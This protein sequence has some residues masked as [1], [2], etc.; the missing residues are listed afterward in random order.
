MKRILLTA[1]LL[2]SACCLSQPSVVSE[3]YLL[4]PQGT[5]EEIGSI[6]ITQTLEGLLFEVDLNNLPTGQHGFHIHEN[7]RCLPSQ[8][9]KGEL[10]LAGQAGGHYDPENTNHHLGPK[11]AGHKGDLPFLL[12]DKEGKVKTSFYHPRLTLKEIKNRSLVI[13]KNGDNYQDKPVPLGGGGDRIACG[14]IE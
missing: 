7:G 9:P 12:A 14:V 11:G 13:H 1:F 8:N 4:S 3:I 10:V 6:K 2:T 5:T